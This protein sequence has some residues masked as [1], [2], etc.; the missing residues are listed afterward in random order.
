MAAQDALAVALSERPVEPAD[1]R[2]FALVATSTRPPAE[3]LEERLL[4]RAL[5]R[6]VIPNHVVVP[7]LVDRPED[8]R[9]LVFDRL[10]KAGVRFD[11]QTLG[12][13]PRALGLLVDHLWPGN[14]R[15]LCDV[16][17]RAAK[18]AVGERVRVTDLERV[19]FVGASDSA[20]APSLS[21]APSAPAPARSSPPVS[22]ARRV[23][24]GSSAS[25][26]GGEAAAS[27]AAR[28]AEEAA[29]GERAGA[30]DASP[31]EPRARRR[32]R[33]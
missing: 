4:S 6:F 20:S 17:E 12:I 16:V 24:R 3:L 1:A 14:V 13:E 28:R 27:V 33:R 9:G 32:R 22:G 10:C 30:D 23:A 8:L 21:A 26:L 29:A 11:G 15:E 18:V 7:A 25:G 2:S 31:E 19:G 5:A